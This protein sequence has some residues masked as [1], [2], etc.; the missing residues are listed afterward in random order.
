MSGYIHSGSNKMNKVEA[1]KNDNKLLLADK[2]GQAKVSS[3][4]ESDLIQLRTDVNKLRGAYVYKGT[5]ETEYD[6]PLND[7]S[8]GDVYNTSAT[9][10]NYAWNGESWDELGTPVN[11]ISEE[12]FELVYS[13]TLTEDSD[14]N[15]LDITAIDMGGKYVDV[16]IEINLP[17]TFNGEYVQPLLTGAPTP[18]S[19]S[20]VPSNAAYVMFCCMSIGGLG[21][22]GM[23]FR[24]ILED[25][26]SESSFGPTIL[27]PA[28]Y[29][30]DTWSGVTN[31][32]LECDNSSVWK[33]GTE[34]KVFARYQVQEL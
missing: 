8:V 28:T 12:Y 18:A 30:N 7:N 33:S 19:A 16:A 13:I 34:I 31:I 17:S 32:R 21:F 20:F 29:P 3:F 14:S 1:Y 24:D 9:G 5:V 4:T 6:L 27:G 23:A 11:G 15:L 10:M 22:T 26:P 25:A 2:L